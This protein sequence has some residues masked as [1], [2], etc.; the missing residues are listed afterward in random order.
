M[1]NGRGGKRPGAGRKPDVA[2]SRAQLLTE[3]FKPEDWLEILAHLK[4]LALS[5]GPDSFRAISLLLHYQFGRSIMPVDR[6]LAEEER[7]AADR[8]SLQSYYDEIA[9]STKIESASCPDAPD[10]PVGLSDDFV[11]ERLPGDLPLKNV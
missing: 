9:A 7:R 4:K 11:Q 3:A 1:S 5:S 10:Q 8:E 6:A 2:R